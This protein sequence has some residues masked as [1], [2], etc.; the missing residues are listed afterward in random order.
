MKRSSQA[1]ARWT[2]ER[3]PLSGYKFTVTNRDDEAVKTLKQAVKLMNKDSST[4]HRVRFMGRGQRTAWARVEG[5]HPRAYDCYLP[6]D[7]ATHF[8]VYVHESS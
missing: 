4:K 7:K 2:K 5:R 3:F 6:L 1:L 8:D